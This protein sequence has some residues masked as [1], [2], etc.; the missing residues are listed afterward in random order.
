MTDTTT[1]V[2]WDHEH[3]WHPFT[4]MR[5]WLADEPLVVA[6][7]EGRTL[8]D[9]DGRRYLD[10]VSS[11]WCNVHGHRHPTLDAALRDQVDRVAH[12]TLLGLG[13]VPSIELAHALA[14]ILPRG[15]TRVFYSD[16]GAT[17]VEVA[18]RM[19]LQYHQLRGDTLRTRFA[20]LVEAYHGDTLGAVGVGYSDAFHRFVADAVVPA[21]RL[22]PPHVFRWQQGHDAARAL[23]LAI[24]DA[25]RVLAEHGP[26]LAA[27]IVEPLVQGAAGMWVHAPEYLRRLRAL[28]TRHG[29]LLIAD[30]VATG[31]GRTG[32]MFACEHAAVTPDLMCVAKGLTGGYLPLAAT[33]ASEEIFQTFLGPYEEFRAFFHGHTYTGNALACAVALANLRV[34]EEERTL[35]RLGPKVARL[36]ARLASDVAPLAHVGDVRQQGFMVGIELV[37]SR[38]GRRPYAPAARVGQRV[39]AAA[40]RRGVILRPLGNVLVL[41]PPLAITEDEL[42]L[43]VDVARDAIREV[44]EAP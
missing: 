4:Q 26:T 13:S 23:A 19:A 10:G 28:A 42:D 16:A 43:L 21:V 44:T 38:D 27:I 5:D 24:A 36:E 11:L 40:R 8:I 20:S 1:L 2:R 18:L 31:F 22:T 30:E 25:E 33:L 9:T 29:T 39:I 32:R 15:L 17:A 12:T 34:F 41:M 14:K 3:L 6:R 37:A 35:E 7:A